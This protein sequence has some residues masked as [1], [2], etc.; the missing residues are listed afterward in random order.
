MKKCYC[1]L[2]LSEHQGDEL[3]GIGGAVQ[4]HMLGLRV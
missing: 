3:A 1:M 4:I 2:K